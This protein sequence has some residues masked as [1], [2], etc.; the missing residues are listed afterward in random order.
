MFLGIENLN[1]RAVRRHISMH[2]KM[3]ALT[4]IA[5]L[6]ILWGRAHGRNKVFTGKRILHMRVPFSATAL[7]AELPPTVSW[8]IE[9]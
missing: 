2:S 6:V 7:Q 1:M 5:C 8:S 3:L 4:F 9:D